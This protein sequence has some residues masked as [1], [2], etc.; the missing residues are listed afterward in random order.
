MKKRLI[1]ALLCAVMLLSAM[2]FA[3][4]ASDLDG[5]W[6]KRFVTY[7][8]QENVINPSKTTGK[9]EPDREMTRA[10]FMRYVNRA[11][12]F[13]EKATISYVD[14]PTGAWYYDTICIAKKYGYIN[15]TGNDRMDPEGKVTREQAAVII[16][17][18]FKADPGTVAP[19]ALPFTDRNTV[20]GW[21]AGYVK[22]AVDKGI[23]TGYKDGSFRPR[24]VVTRGEVAK[25][26]YHYLGT[27]LSRQGKAYT[28]TDL[29]QDTANV[30]ISESCTL[31]NATI[32]GDLYLTEGLG[33]DAVT[34]TNVNVEGT[35]IVSG[36]TVTLTNTSSDHMIVS[37]PMG[38]L[39]QVTVTG[40]SN[41][42]QAEVCTAAALYEKGLIGENSAG[43][44]DVLVKGKGRVSLTLDAAVDELVLAGEA[45]VSTTAGATVYRLEAQQPASI[46][47]Y[48]EVYQAD[49]KT[50]GVSFASS[51]S[52]LGHTLAD[53]L[54]ATIG[55]KTVSG[56]SMA[57]VSPAVIE[58]DLDDLPALGAGVEVY[59]PAGVSVVSASCGGQTLA[60]TT[61]HVRT[62]AGIRLLP[63]FLGSLGQG[64][65]ALTLMLSDGGRA[66]LTIRVS[67]ASAPQQV[68]QR[69]TFDRYHRSAGFK[70]LVLRLDGVTTLAD[71][72]GVV[73]GLTH[74]PYAFDATA[75]S[76]VVRRSELARLR[77]GTYTISIDC[78]DGTHCAV[79]LTVTDSTPAGVHAVVAV[80]DTFAPTE[81]SIDLPL[82]GAAVRS[83]S[84]SSNGN[85]Q[86][87]QAGS[88]YRV[89]T[90]SLTLTKDTLEHFRHRGSCT[91]F[92]VTL[93]DGTVC[94][95][96]VDYI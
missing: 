39:L 15:G 48:G 35:L 20:A 6:A 26:L 89:G 12:H 34:L 30:T 28:G 38:R 78:A 91:A 92:D 58:V 62:N 36:G 69:A 85:V 81:V 51:V 72:D 1:S 16:G 45:T 86:E 47:G 88:A 17:R 13:T 37:S 80:Y 29:K 70:D 40:A 25:I 46:T 63:A 21:A 2:P 10:E 93:T 8:D 77:A 50:G 53:G 74:L 67:S 65:H 22:A 96:V 18:L 64:E 49:I 23:L 3:S 60:N 7:L 61:D 27:S 19:S 14:V 94:T 84:V 75:R 95:L 54:T 57:G 31:S 59:M 9:Y 33:A 79:D 87:L 68:V 71:I 5:H 4:A 42:Q 73:L 44:D 32:K 11:F 83:V 90:Q 82:G 56:S 76:V 43:F 24:R 66:D 52:V 55:G 41:I